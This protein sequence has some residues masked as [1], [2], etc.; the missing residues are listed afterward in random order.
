MTKTS[1]EFCFMDKAAA[2]A[3]FFSLSLFLLSFCFYLCC[4]RCL[5]C[6]ACNACNAAEIGR[7][8][9]GRLTC[10]TSLDFVQCVIARKSISEFALSPLNTHTHKLRQLL[11]ATLFSPSIGQS[12]LWAKLLS[13]HQSDQSRA[14]TIL[15]VDFIWIDKQVITLNDFILRT[16]TQLLCLRKWTRSK[17]TPTKRFEASKVG[18]LEE[19]WAN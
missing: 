4:F 18:C 3:N 16:H 6:A 17:Q 15:R 12:P 7:L 2:G 10:R 19:V 9:V 8:Q 1:G 11:A 5:F 13:A 14:L